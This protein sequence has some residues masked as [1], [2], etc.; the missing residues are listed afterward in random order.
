MARKGRIIKAAI[1]SQQKENSMNLQRRYAHYTRV[2]ILK[3]R[4]NIH[5]ATEV[6]VNTIRVSTTAA[7]WITDPDSVPFIGPLNFGQE[8]DANQYIPLLTSDNGKNV[9]T[10]AKID[11]DPYVPTRYTVDDYVIR[12][13]PPKKAGDDRP[14]KYGTY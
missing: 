13:Y 12:R 5:S 11:V 10:V 6:L 9:D 8:G 3:R 14:E 4:R 1:S 7:T 2:P